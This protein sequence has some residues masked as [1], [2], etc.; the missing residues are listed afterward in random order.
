M[1]TMTN[2]IVEGHSVGIN[3]AVDLRDHAVNRG[4]ARPDFR[5]IECNQP[6][7]AQKSGGFAAE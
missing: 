6:V 4:V 7:R 3:I 2:C 1:V 5:C